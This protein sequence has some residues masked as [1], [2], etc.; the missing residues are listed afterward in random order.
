M[1]HVGGSVAGSGFKLWAGIRQGD[2]LS[3]M[4]F[5]FATLF[6]IERMREKPILKGKM[7][8]FWYVDNSV[9]DIKPTDEILEEV[10]R[11]YE[12]FRKA[13]GLV[14]NMKKSAIMAQEREEGTEIK[15]FKV[16]HSIKHS[17]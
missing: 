11:E 4:L 13:S 14:T 16:S 12:E 9:V 7:E 15:G 8:N 1:M 17:G 5:V 10:L 3:P 2:P 6:I